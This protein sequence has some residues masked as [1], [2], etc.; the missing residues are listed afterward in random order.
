[1]KPKYK[2]KHI[3]I[4][5]TYKSP[6]IV[7]FT[8]AFVFL[9]F[10][11]ISWGVNVNKYL[12]VNCTVCKIHNAKEKS[13]VL[14]YVKPCKKNPSLLK[15]KNALWYKSTVTSRYSCFLK[16]ETSDDEC[17][18][19]EVNKSDFNKEKINSDS[20]ITLT[21]VSGST[22]LLYNMFWGRRSVS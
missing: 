16:S 4:N 3:L 9:L 22:K 15:K 8:V 2:L 14:L 1:M 6:V 19:L 12:D 11:V 5:I 21:V 13:K 10:F 17:I 18:T 7:L 20:K